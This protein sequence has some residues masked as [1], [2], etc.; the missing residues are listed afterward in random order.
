M[1]KNTGAATVSHQGGLIRNRAATRLW[2]RTLG[3]SVGP[4]V[5]GS[6][7]PRMSLRLQKHTF[8]RRGSSLERTLSRSA[9]GAVAETG[10]GAGRKITTAPK[11]FVVAM[12]DLF[13][14]KRGWDERD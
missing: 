5:V 2:D 7:Q 4:A 3:T 10:T 1:W 14:H 13:P 8:W 9:V 12:G 6:G 11:A